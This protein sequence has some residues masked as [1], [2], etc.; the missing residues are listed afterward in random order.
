MSVRL[1][2]LLAAPPVFGVVLGYLSGGR[3]GRLRAIP[4]RALWLVW[5]AAAAQF[6]QYR[7]PALRGVVG[8]SVVFAV[9]L[10]WLALNLPRWPAALR[11]AG[12]LIVLGA[13]LNGVAISLNGRMPYDSR[14]AVGAGL[15]AGDETPKNVAA[16]D[17]TRAA[18]L[19]DT[20]PIVALRALIS[21]GD[22]LIGGGACAFVLLAMRRPERRIHDRKTVLAPADAGALHP[23]RAGAAALH[24]RRAARARRLTP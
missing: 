3:L 6:A 7:I 16:N 12:V 20:I 4:V 24:D 9:V 13:S 2:I 10:T 22:I 23:G 14:A 5:L 1:A 21:P 8:L 15:P 11:I 17:R 18:L 19:G